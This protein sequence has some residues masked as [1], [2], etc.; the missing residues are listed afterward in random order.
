MVNFYNLTDIINFEKAPYRHI[1]IISNES[2]SP[3]T[4]ILTTI[5]P[6]QIAPRNTSET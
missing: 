1:L 3:V 6:I 5:D 4:K 2:N